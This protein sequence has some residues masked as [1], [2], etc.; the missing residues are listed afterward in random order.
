MSLAGSEPVAFLA[1]TDLARA[2]AFF[3]DVLGLQLMAED[4]FAC[5][6]RAG[7]VSLRVSLVEQIVTAPYTVLGWIVPNIG[8]AIAELSAQGVAFQQFDGLDQDELGVWRTP[9][10][11]L[12]AWFRDPDGSVLSLTQRT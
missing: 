11:S 1:A 6:F 3:G 9:D 2:R 4:G 8:Q 5:M 12:V 10:G 7:A